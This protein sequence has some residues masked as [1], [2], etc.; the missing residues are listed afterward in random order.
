MNFWPKLATA[1]TTDNQTDTSISHTI[2]RRFIQLKLFVQDCKIIITI[3]N[4]S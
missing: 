3:L 2:P 1:A 4:A